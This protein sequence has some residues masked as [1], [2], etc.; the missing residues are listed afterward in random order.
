[1]AKEFAHNAL[2]T[3]DGV[4]MTAEQRLQHSLAH[5]DAQNA[6]SVRAMNAITKARISYALG[7]LAQ[8][9]I[10]SVQ[11]WLERVAEVNPRQAVELY[12]QLLE[13]SVPK[14]KAVEVTNLG[15]PEKPLAE[16]T[17]AELQARVVSNQ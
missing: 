17:L 2:V 12:L 7:E 15:Q 16:Y 6:M 8:L 14:L 9:N 11:Q 3:D 13:F 5:P 1:M 10:P 4:N